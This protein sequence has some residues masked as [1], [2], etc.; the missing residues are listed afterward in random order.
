[1]KH[2]LSGLRVYHKTRQDVQYPAAGPGKNRTFPGAWESR[3]C[4]PTRAPAAGHGNHHTVLCLLH[5]S[6][7]Y[8]PS[9]RAR[10][11]IHAARGFAAAGHL[12]A[13]RGCF[14]CRPAAFRWARCTTPAWAEPVTRIRPTS[15]RPGVISPFQI[16]RYGA[17]FHFALSWLNS[18][19]VTG[20]RAGYNARCDAR[21]AVREG[22]T[23]GGADGKSRQGVPPALP[24]PM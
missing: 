11:G 1:M 2:V 23:P 7:W 4:P 3:S 13:P 15:P 14:P 8:F 16:N 10:F 21:P 24:G 12:P 22:R 18:A 17:I 20:G 19:R 5:H 9:A 6:R